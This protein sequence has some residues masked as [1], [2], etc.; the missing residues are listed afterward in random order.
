MSRIPFHRINWPTSLFLSITLL[1]SVTAL[2][3]YL[4]HFGLDWFQIVLLLVTFAASSMSITL[5][6][7]RLF[8]HMAFKAKWPVK[9]GVLVFG[10]SAFEGSALEWCTD[11]RRHHKFVDHDD[12]PYDITKGFFHA[13]MGWLLFKLRP[14]PP[15][16]NVPDL[17]A[18]RMVMFQHRHFP[19]IGA[20]VNLVCVPAIG[21][22]WGGWESALGALLIGSV[23]R[24]VLVEHSTFC[25]N[26]FCHMIGSRP[27]STRCSARNSWIMALFTF[28][29]GYH[30]YHHEFQHDYRNGV[31]PWQFDPTKW[32][33]WMMSK[34][35][36]TSGLRRVPDEK[37]Q[38][39]EI[40]EQQKQLDAVM[41]ARPAKR[42]ETTRRLLDA[43]QEQLHQAAQTW[44][45][46]KTEYMRATEKKIEAS[47]EKIAQLNRDFEEAAANLRRAIQEWQQAHQLARARFA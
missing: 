4:W 44:E 8:S 6:Y 34:I 1:I 2:P 41:A 28:G 17:L 9:L 25:I 47:K 33:I 26:S 21:W 15:M 19:L 31:K 18:D 46:R 42:C 7:H 10:A 13:H 12:D 3:V 40:A 37:I 39:A 43:A 14:V 32:A 16:D 5:G 29:E 45:L 36:L 20:I 27:Y 24:V 38:L 22:L 11:H 35:G 30:N 23:L